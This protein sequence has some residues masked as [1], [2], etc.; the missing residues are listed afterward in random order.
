MQSAI[1][2]RQSPA[3]VVRTR[4]A[5]AST[6]KLN[7]TPSASA[8]RLLGRFLQLAALICLPLTIP[9]QLMH[10]IDTRFMIG[11]MVGSICLFY[12]GRIV[13]GYAGK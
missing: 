1:T 11:L 7:R 10:V 13:E 3:T 9:L 6:L 2:G 4:R 5:Y 8:M 12:L